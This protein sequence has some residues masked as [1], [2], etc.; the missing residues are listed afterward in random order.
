MDRYLIIDSESGRII[1]GA[2][3][4]ATVEAL[5][6]YWTRKTHRAYHCKPIG[7]S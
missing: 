4:P 6:T 1:T 7:A 2:N 3:T 5:L